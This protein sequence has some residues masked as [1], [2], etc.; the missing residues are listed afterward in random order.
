HGS[1]G[2]PVRE[3]AAA[4]RKVWGGLDRYTKR[5]VLL[6][7][8]SRGLYAREE[9]RIL[10]I[11]PATRFVLTPAGEAAQADLRAWLAVGQGEARRWTGSNAALAAA[12]LG[13]AG[14]AA[15]LL[16]PIPPQLQQLQ[17]RQLQG[18]HADSTGSTGSSST[19]GDDEGRERPEP[20]EPA[21]PEEE[22]GGGDFSLDLD[23]DAFGGFDSL[24]S[25]FASI[26]SG[27]DSG[28]GGSSDGGGGDGGGDGGGGGE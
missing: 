22:P 26:D 8:A 19:G 17:R 3:L 6:A 13:S 23:L 14:A 20:G 25:A 11:F 1:A 28:D 4:A 15:L 7:L 9:R 27:V 5:V 16:Q 2:V 24:D 10:W 12:F 21:P 18:G